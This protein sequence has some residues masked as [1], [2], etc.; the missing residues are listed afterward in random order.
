MIKA[1]KPAMAMRQTMMR[2][3]FCCG[4]VGAGVGVMGVTGAPLGIGGIGGVVTTG[5]T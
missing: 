5:V 3:M 2:G 1:S 4:R